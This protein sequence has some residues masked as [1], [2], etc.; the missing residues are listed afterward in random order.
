MNAEIA[1]KI[2]NVENNLLYESAFK[3]NGSGIASLFERMKY[4]KVPGVSIAIINDFKIEWAKG[5]GTKEAGV[6]NC[7]DENTLFQAA[8]ISKTV[9]AAAVVCLARQGIL[10]LDEDISTYLKSWFVPKN[11]G[12]K[13]QITLRQLLSHTAGFT[14]HGFKGYRINEPVPNLIQILNGQPPCNSDAV[15]VDTIPG[16][17]CRYSGGGY[18][19]AQQ[20]VADVTGMPIPQLMKDIILDPLGMGSSTFEQPLPRYLQNIA[21]VAHSFNGKPIEGRC[22]VYPER[23]AAGLWT[24]PTDLTKFGIAM[25]LALKGKS[26]VFPK[27][28]ADEMLMPQTEN[29][30]GLGFRLYGNGITARFGHGGSNEGYRARA[31]FYKALGMGAVVMIN[32]LRL[33]LITE[34]EKAIATVYGW[35]DFLPV[36]RE[37]IELPSQLLCNYTGEY[38]TETGM[39]FSVMAKNGLLQL[40]FGKQQPLNIFP[41]S[42]QEFIIKEVNANVSF[43]LALGEAE[44]LTVHQNDKKIDAIRVR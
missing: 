31:T 26:N 11:E 38:A 34:I 15:V 27:D 43:A 20:V 7:I 16:L 2:K 30:Y 5:Y 41:I 19:V 21:A 10:S 13:P 42:H 22:H 25:Q 37:I 14:V 28:A 44:R 4:Y 1:D 17:Q 32:S 35:P 18:S 9:F 12:W 6:L 24:T 23:A 39:I 33:E 36:D 29:I 3:N 8:S 40:R